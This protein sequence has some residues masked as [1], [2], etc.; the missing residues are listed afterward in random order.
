MSDAKHARASAL[1]GADAPKRA[2]KAKRASALLGTDAEKLFIPPAM[3]EKLWSG[4]LA[5]E[6]PAAASKVDIRSGTRD[7][8]NLA[9]NRFTLS[10]LVPQIA[11]NIRHWD[12]SVVL[13]VDKLRRHVGWEPEL[14][15]PAAV[16]RTW[17]WYQAA[18]LPD[19]QG[20]DFGF[21]DELIRM[22]RDWRG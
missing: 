5:I 9:I 6:L 4:E 7:R 20:F 11:P 12:R 21:E 13:S 1:L 8:D 2:A 17:R 18:G 15:F 10:M 14:T 22:V 19:T 16:E 3:M